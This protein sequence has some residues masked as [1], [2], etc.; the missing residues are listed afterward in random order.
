M[1]E[2]ELLVERIIKL[3]DNKFRKIKEV[4]D[5]IEKE[6]VNATEKHLS[7]TQVKL[8]D[9]MKHTVSTGRGDFSINHDK[10]LYGIENE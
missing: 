3:P 1:T 8:L 7:D 6:D 9:L 2:R 5:S 4:L 10:Y